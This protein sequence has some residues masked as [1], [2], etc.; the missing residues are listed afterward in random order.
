[1]LNLFNKGAGKT[2]SFQLANSS[3]TSANVQIAGNHLGEQL[4]VYQTNAANSSAAVSI[5]NSGTGIG[6]EAT[7]T[8]GDAVVGESNTGYGIKGVTNTALGKA[9]VHGQNNG[10]AGSG[11]V[12]ISNAANT[13]GVY[14]SS[15]NG[16][17][18][19]ALSTNC[20]AL[21]VNGKVKIAGGNTNP[22]VGKVLTSDASG[23]ATWQD[24]NA[25]PI[26]GF[27]ASGLM[28]AF[29]E[30]P[31]SAE[32]KVQFESQ[33]YDLGN[34]FID[35]SENGNLT[36][37]NVFHVPVN[38][39][40]HFDVAIPFALKGPGIG[41]HYDYSYAIA[42]IQLIRNGNTSEVA[43]FVEFEAGIKPSVRGGTDLV[44]NA[45]DKIYITVRQSTLL[46]L[47]MPLD[48]FGYNEMLFSGHLVRKL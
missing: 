13:Q 37:A 8:T 2:G 16:I 32:T 14:G 33:V 41:G 31:Y 17:A 45:G 12:G 47:S 24:V 29:P 25:G 21:D 22:G 1:L 7:S 6:I 10:A 26:V 40:Y 43:K 19:R 39:L 46:Q 30:V 38:G 44:L 28:E 11:V 5:E 20:T 48:D 4:K 18:V 36:E 3:S 42:S 35:L 27:K 9:G 34:N 23:N 15:A